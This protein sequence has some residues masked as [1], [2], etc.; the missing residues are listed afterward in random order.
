MALVAFIV[1]TTDLHVT[2]FDLN[3]EQ[4]LLVET[5]TELAE[6]EFADNAFEWEGDTP[7]ENLELLA[8][9]GFLGINL[10]EEYGGAGMTEF[11]AILVLEIIGRV[12]PDTAYAMYGQQLV[13]ARAIDEFGTEAAKE[14]YL[15]PV[16]GG[17]EL[18]AIAISEPGAGSDVQS[19]TTEAEVTDDSVIINGEK[20]WVSNIQDSTAA[21]TWAQFPDGIGSVIIDLN[22]PGVEIEQAYTNMTGRKQTHFYLNDIEVPEYKVLNWG[23]FG[24][25]LWM[26]NWERL[27]I[28]AMANAMMCCALDHSLDYAE[29]R[30]QFGQPIGEFQGIEWKLA[31]MTMQTEL[32]RAITFQAGLAA[33]NQ[34]R[35]PDRLAAS[36]AKLFA[37]RACEEVTSEAVQ[38]HGANG[39]QQGHPVEYLYRMGRRWRIGGGTDEIIK[40]S[41]AQAI[42]RNGIPKIVDYTD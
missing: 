37:A 32:S 20:M 23:D 15:P 4:K 8:E 24:K 11:E 22:D 42:K 10:D 31:D 29:D 38:I 7:W 18:I 36:V 28:A 17:E 34:G 13:T 21:V 41:I 25:Q 33:V 27:G 3:T 19:M 1:D 35:N 30:E 16:I 2:V 9:N 14:E 5:A 12:C 6:K 26:L 39:F 40:N